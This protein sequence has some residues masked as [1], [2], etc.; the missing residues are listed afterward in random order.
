M[1]LRRADGGRADAPA[2]I[3]V[4]GAGGRMT[5]VLEKVCRVDP[6][7]QVRAVFDP[8]PESVEL[9]RGRV[10]RDVETCPDEAAL[11]ARGDLDWVFIGS[12]NH[13]HARQAC[14]ALEAGRHVFCEKPLA[15]SLDEAE[16]MHAAWR[17][18]GR[19]VVLG[20]VLRY[21]PLYRAAKAAI[22]S[23][24][25][26]R[27]LSFEF[28]ETLSFNHGGY[29]HGNWR[30]HRRLAGSHVLE[31]CCHDLDLALW[32]LDDL[33]VRVASFGGRSFFHAAHAGEAARVG[34][35][36]SSGRPA[37]RAW[38]DRHGV[39]PFNDDKDIV[40]HQVAILEFSRGTRGTFHTQCLAALPERRFYILGSEGSLR[41]DAYTGRLELCRVGW[42]E[43]VEISEP[44][45]L[46]GSGGH[47]GSDQPMA[48]QLAACMAGRAE[49]AAGIA[50]GVRSL[51]LA[52]ALDEA[53]ER[54]AVVDLKPS[55]AR[56]ARLLGGAA[57][58]GLR[59]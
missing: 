5:G 18:S 1:S 16:R 15:L 31:K 27:V 35:D 7:V 56:V 49:P 4:I 40:D 3:G 22:A 2:R 59:G 55:W 39:D 53:M 43:E 12:P 38:P 19:Q 58:P 45:A 11:C 36:P 46:E 10:A 9:F 54:A 6:S 28:N 8:D 25:I 33:P 17:S 32:L 30:R 42:R 14:M 23:G 41:L 34:P 21:S 50:E 57:P 52:L 47:A 26:G 37:F 51:V 13:A 20:L 24:R 29:I 48:E 44:A